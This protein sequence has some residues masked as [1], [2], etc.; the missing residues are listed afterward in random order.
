MPVMA[1]ASANITS[2]DDAVGVE[3][4]VALLGVEGAAEALGVLGLPAHDVVVVQLQ[5]LVA[6][7]LALGQEVVERARGTARR[8]TAGTPRTAARRGRRPR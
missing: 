4:L 5:G 7:G 2:A 1:S 3:L 8:G 6:A